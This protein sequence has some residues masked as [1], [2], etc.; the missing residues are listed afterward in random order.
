MH[1]NNGVQ[2]GEQFSN[3]IEASNDDPPMASLLTM[4]IDAHMVCENLH[5]LA[6]MISDH[7]FGPTPKNGT[8]GENK[9]SRGAMRETYNLVNS[10]I[11]A[12]GKLETI[13]TAIGD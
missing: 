2:C 11:A 1:Q 12:R 5:T 6:D 7:L 3:R 13:L 10:L 9:A 4:L 8:C